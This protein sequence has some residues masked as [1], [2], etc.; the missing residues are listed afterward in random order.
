MG[1]VAF[2][3]A[4]GAPGTTTTALLAAALWPTPV[5]L[6][7]ADPEGGD[8][9]LRLRRQ[10]GAPV[11]RSRGLLS[12]L[13]LAR[14]EMQPA[15]LPEHAQ[16]LQGGTEVIAGLS[17]P[18][19]A[20]A[21]GH[22]WSNLAD[23]FARTADRDVLLDC[24]RVSPRSVHL[25][26]LQQADLLVWVVRP[27]VSSV[28][29]TRERLAALS[30]ALGASDGHRPRVGVVLVADKPG[31]RDAHGAA[32]VLERDL[33]GVEVFGVLALDAPGA[34]VFD[35]FEIPRP[36]RTLLVR[37]GRQVVAELVTALRHERRGAGS[38]LAATPAVPA[39]QPGPGAAGGRRAAPRRRLFVRA[40][41]E[42]AQRR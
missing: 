23:A 2:L 31:G 37:S 26:L 25:P 17:G 38:A 24:G 22:L 19:Q 20:G 27:T 16:V 4:K 3:S 11:D 18:E 15:T 40:R 42:G 34:S 28:I 33:P 5:L 21:A 7:D 29:H 36:E 13:P 10:D 8:I 41:Q 12:L 9:A 14:R 1:V 39:D 6:V 32:G 35:G 30:P